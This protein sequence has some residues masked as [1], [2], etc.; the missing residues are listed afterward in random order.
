MRPG[1][2]VAERASPAVGASTEWSM[3]TVNISES[4]MNSV[5]AAAVTDGNVQFG[6]LCCPA[7]SAGRT[8]GVVSVAVARNVAPFSIDGEPAAN[9]SSYAQGSCGDGP[10]G[11]DPGARGPSHVKVP[12]PLTA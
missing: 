5:E 7:Q 3:S 9:S 8:C 6:V 11:G 10:A 12:L 2:A 4:A 1:I